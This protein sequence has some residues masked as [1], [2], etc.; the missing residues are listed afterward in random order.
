M[1]LPVLL[2]VVL[3]LGAALADP[4]A[5]E[6]DAAPEA[7]SIVKAPLTLGNK[8]YTAFWHLP[9]G[10]PLGFIQVQHGFSRNCNHQRDTIARFMNQGLMALCLN[11]DMSGGNPALADRLAAA[12]VAGLT[13]PDGRPVPEMIV[14]AGHSAGGHFASRLGWTLASLVPQRLVGAVL[15]DP[16][17]ADS[18]FTTNLRGVSAA[19]QR[20]VLAVSANAGACNAQNNAYPALRRV[21]AEALAAGRD[22]FVGLQLTDRSTHVDSEGNNTDFLGWSACFQGKPRPVNTGTLRDLTSTWARDQVTGLRTLP[23]YPGGSGV[24]ALL[25]AGDAVLID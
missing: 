3:A 14:V 25:A 17:A 23:A 15:F 16:V 7:G 8:T 19:G 5:A 18:S 11:A 12:L 24:E 6:T 22:G 2:P 20:P 4:A 9:A 13:A 1:N 10:E 21:Q